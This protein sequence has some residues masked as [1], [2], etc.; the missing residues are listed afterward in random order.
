M[1]RAESTNDERVKESNCQ[2]APT[3]HAQF[4]HVGFALVLGV[5]KTYSFEFARITL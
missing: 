1:T 2:V 4:P 5:R 3:T